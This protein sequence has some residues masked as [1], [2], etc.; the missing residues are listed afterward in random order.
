M[1]LLEKCNNCKL[2]ECIECEYTW[3]DIAETSKNFISK[4]KI[5]EKIKDIEKKIEFEYDDRVVVWLYKQKRALQDLLEE[6]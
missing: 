5:R 1:N 3:S 2:E 4:D 6:E